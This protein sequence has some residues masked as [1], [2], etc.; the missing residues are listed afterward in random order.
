VGPGG[1]D[2]YGVKFARGSAEFRIDIGTDG[3]IEDLNFR[4]DGDGTPGGLPDCAL[5]PTLKSSGDAA[6]IDLA[7]ANRTGVELRLF[8][9]DPDGRRRS[10]GMIEADASKHVPS[11]IARP[12][13]RGSKPNSAQCPQFRRAACR[14]A[15]PRH[16]PTRR[17]RHERHRH[18]RTIA[19]I[20]RRTT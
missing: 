17:P 4:P 12:L 14:P 8:R 7:L 20:V 19:T 13:S 16:S 2:I 15:G 6:P 1:Y 5:E 18:R 10:Q 11:Y 9:L 3:T